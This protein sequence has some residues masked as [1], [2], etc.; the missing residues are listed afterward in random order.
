LSRA[1]P[2]AE[3]WQL[4]AVAVKAVLVRVDAAAAVGARR[5]ALAA[6]L[7]DLVVL[8]AAL[9]AE[10]R[11][12]LAVLAPGAQA[13]VPVDLTVLMQRAVL[14]PALA[15]RMADQVLLATEI[16]AV[17]DPGKKSRWTLSGGFF[18]LLI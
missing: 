1:A 4:K 16:R 17:F 15:D 7:A 5:K 14:T 13:A 12:V 10:G 11:V 3:A 9:T 6:A 18:L 2:A 8:M